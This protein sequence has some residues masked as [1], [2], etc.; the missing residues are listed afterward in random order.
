MAALLVAIRIPD[1]VVKDPKKATLRQ[2]LD[3]LDLLGATLFATMIIMFLLALE[4]GGQTYP[5]N[6]ATIIGLFVGSFGNLLVFL[7]WERHRGSTAMI[8][9]AMLGKRV[10]YSSALTSFFMMGNL[11]V[12]TYYLAIWFQVV[13]GATPT[14][15]GVYLLPSVL[16]QMFFAIVSGLLGML[17]LFLFGP[18]RC[19]Q[20]SNYD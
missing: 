3:K 15:S 1:R 14:L 8:P 19:G 6:S 5:W 7:A 10:V 11:I 12:T 2:T 20:H 13:R 16:S 4:W 17:L 9:L 18:Q